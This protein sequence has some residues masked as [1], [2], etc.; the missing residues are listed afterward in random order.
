M[1]FG[2]RRHLFRDPSAYHCSDSRVAD[3]KGEQ[4][5]AVSI[6]AIATSILSMA[7]RAALDKESTPV[8]WR[9]VIKRSCICSGRA[10]FRERASAY[11]QGRPSLR[12]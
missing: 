9:R 4:I 3:R 2:K 5:R 7:V 10:R 11:A 6:L 12:R 8:A 1:L